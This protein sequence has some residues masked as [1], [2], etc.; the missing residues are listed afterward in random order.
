MIR[1]LIVERTMLMCNLTRVAIEQEDMVVVGATTHMPG[2][3]DALPMCDVLT[4]RHEPLD[5]LALRVIEHA[6]EHHP[7]I[8]PMVL[9]VPQN[10]PLILAYIEAGAAG[11]ALDT[12]SL[13]SSRCQIQSVYHGEPVV[14]PTVA[15]NIMLRMRELTRERQAQLHGEQSANALTLR[16][17]EVM[18]AVA[19]SLTNRQIAEKLRIGVGTVKNHV[20]SIL[21]KLNVANRKAA[22]AYFATLYS[23]FNPPRA[24][25]ALDA[26]ANDG[27]SLINEPTFIST[28]PR[29]I[30]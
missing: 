9:N 7:G 27:P 17:R 14:C 29:L 24:N 3:I 2:A 26:D 13:S 12:D 20:H 30:Q 28:P 19:Q 18:N 6:A 16:E 11:Y 25:T 1:V 15:A 8:K 5:D 10:N 4:V 21:Q 23:S 22:A